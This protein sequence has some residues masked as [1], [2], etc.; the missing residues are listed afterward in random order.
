MSRR[1]LPMLTK[2]LGV[3]APLGGMAVGVWAPELE[4][5]WVLVE[6]EGPS[7]S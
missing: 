1:G 7:G 3:Y 2:F 5:G 4:N 6:V